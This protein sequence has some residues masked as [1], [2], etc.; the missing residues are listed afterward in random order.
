[1]L[2]RNPLCDPCESRPRMHEPRYLDVKS[3]AAEC[4]SIVCSTEERRTVLVCDA[5]G[6]TCRPSAV[7][8]VQAAV[9]EIMRVVVLVLHWVT[10]GMR[11]AAALERRVAILEHEQ[12][13]LEGKVECLFARVALLAD[14]CGETFECSEC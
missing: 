2:V 5:R 14:R 9:V 4:L 13:A 1:M 3:D 8:L 12:R 11:T 6:R 10:E 7:E